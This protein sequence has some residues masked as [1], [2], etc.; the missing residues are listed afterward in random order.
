MKLS[1]LK[2]SRPTTLPI[3]F[4]D[5]DRVTIVYDRSVLTQAF[6]A[7]SRPIVEKVADVLLS[8]D[9]TDDDGKL[10]QPPESANGS[11]PK[12]W[13]A[14]LT[15]LPAVVTARIYHAIWDDIWA[16]PKAAAGSSDS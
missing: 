6:A 15:P 2:A 8:W 16:G 9:V 14:L 1:K 12:E 10:C 7:T 13:A 4:D 3:D 5:G 11:R